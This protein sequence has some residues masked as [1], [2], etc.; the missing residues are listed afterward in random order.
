ML[1]FN[2]KEE[3]RDYLIKAN[4]AYRVGTPI[5]TDRVYDML[6]DQFRSLDPNDLFLNKI[7]DRDF[8]LEKPLTIMM[9]SQR[10]A[11]SLE[12]L[13]SF[14]EKVRGQKLNISEKLDGMS[15]ELTYKNGGFIQALTRGDGKVGV[16]ITLIVSQI[17]SIPLMIDEKEKIVVRGE[18]LLSKSQLDLLN[19]SRAKE[20]LDI[21]TNTRNGAVALCKSLKN[22]KYAKHLSFKAFDILRMS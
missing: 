22:K 8:G 3:L 10:K 5:I 2:T 9:G 13:D 21:Y 20:N 1:N 4:D 7:D 16:D 17:P 12:E 11:L 6:E 14:I 19:E 18:V 15:C